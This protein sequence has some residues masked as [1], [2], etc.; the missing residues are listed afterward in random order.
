MSEDTE[1][2]EVAEKDIPMEDC[3]AAYVDVEIIEDKERGV[4]EGEENIVK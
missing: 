2:D 4:I 1:S 3:S